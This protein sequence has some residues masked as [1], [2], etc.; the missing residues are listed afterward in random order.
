MVVCK[1]LETRCKNCDK[2]KESIHTISQVFACCLFRNTTP[3]SS[4]QEA[5]TVNNVTDTSLTSEDNTADQ[6]KPRPL[7]PYTM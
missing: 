7:S 4:V 3:S 6:P 5:A 1:Y 2:F